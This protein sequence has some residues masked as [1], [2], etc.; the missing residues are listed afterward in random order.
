MTRLIDEFRGQYFWLSNFFCAPIM[1]NGEY[2]A[3]TE[4]AYQAAKTEDEK[5]RKEI[6]LSTCARAR[7]LGQKVTLKKDWSTSRTKVMYDIV[8]LKFE[9]HPELKSKLLATK[10]AYLVEGNHWHD[11]FWGSCSC[12]NCPDSGENHLGLILAKIR[13]ELR[14]TTDTDLSAAL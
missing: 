4:H 3:S 12:G 1:Y 7:D 10:S 14:E 9:T 6:Q 2:Y 11:N 5:E 13:N 8:K